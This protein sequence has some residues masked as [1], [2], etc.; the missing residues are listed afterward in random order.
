MWW[1]PCKLNSFH[2]LM[3]SLHTIFKAGKT[4]KL[5]VYGLSARGIQFSQHLIETN[6]INEQQALV[7]QQTWNHNFLHSGSSMVSVYLFSLHIFSL[8]VP[9]HSI[10]ILFLQIALY[11]AFIFLS[12]IAMHAEHYSPAPTCMSHLFLHSPLS[13]SIQ[14]PFSKHNI[15]FHTV[16]TLPYLPLECLHTHFL[17]VKILLTFQLCSW[18]IS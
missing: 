8:L 4:A 17:S 2:P 16:V 3:K 5:E 9:L 13:S 12:T 10:G 18:S 7:I 6:R 14:L 11:I 15:Y 1:K